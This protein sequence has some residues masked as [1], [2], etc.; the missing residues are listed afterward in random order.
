[1][2]EALTS[3]SGGDR[4]RR[5]SESSAT[6]MMPRSVQLGRHGMTFAAAVPWC[7]VRLVAPRWPQ[8]CATAQDQRGRKRTGAER[9]METKLSSTE[10]C[11]GSCRCD[12]CF[13]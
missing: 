9:R 2:P 5:T 4:A 11:N 3:A 13:D 12:W 8:L 10:G 7:G 1:M 6:R